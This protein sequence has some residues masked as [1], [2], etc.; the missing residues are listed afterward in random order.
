MDDWYNVTH[1]DIYNWGGHSILREYYN[2]SPSKALGNVYPEHQWILHKFKRSPRGYWRDKVNQNNFFDW[3]GIQLRYKHMADWYNVTLEDIYECG[4]KA[5]MDDYYNKSIYKA[6]STI[7]PTHSWIPWKFNKVP[8]SFWDT[9]M[10]KRFFQWLGVQLGYNDMDNWYNISSDDIYKHGGGGF[11]MTFYNNSPTTALQELYPEHEWMWWRFNCAP[12]GLWEQAMK[13]PSQQRKIIYW[14]HEHLHIQ[15]LEDWYRVSIH[16]VQKCVR[17][18][19][20]RMLTQMLTSTFPVHKWDVAKLTRLGGSIKA[21]QRDLMVRV[22]QL[23]PGQS[24]SS[25]FRSY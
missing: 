24:I 18:L 3:T 9:N 21:A 22:L 17:I 10:R 14:L 16:Q 23:F 2:A 15:N 5:L 11:P 19:T 20:T 4:G 1:K 13:D 6:L 7:Y 8:R 25:Y 12:H